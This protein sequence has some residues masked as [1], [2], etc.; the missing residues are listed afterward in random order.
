MPYLGDC[1]RINLSVCNELGVIKTSL[2]CAADTAVPNLVTLRSEVD[3]LFG[4]KLVKL[5]L[6]RY[7]LT[8]Q[9][10]ADHTGWNIARFDTYDVSYVVGKFDNPT[11]T[12]PGFLAGIH[13]SVP[14]SAVETFVLNFAKMP[15]LSTP[16]FVIFSKPKNRA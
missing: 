16:D 7:E 4:G 8:E 13:K 5:S 10:K 15:D 9:E 3:D 2:P 11:A 12:V 14:I 1:L 6:G